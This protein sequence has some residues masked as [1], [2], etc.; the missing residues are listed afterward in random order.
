MINKL[1][2]YYYTFKYDPYRRGLA[3][4]TV[5]GIGSM[6][7][8]GYVIRANYDHGSIY[9]PWHVAESIK[10]TGTSAMTKQWG[11]HFLITLVPKED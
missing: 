1:R 9:I 7:V 4:G 3:A 6:V 8:A 10:E 5:L 11:D 2:E